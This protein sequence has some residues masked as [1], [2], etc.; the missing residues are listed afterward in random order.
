MTAR[1]V[2]ADEQVG[3]VDD[4]RAVALERGHL[5]HR[6]IGE[7]IGLPERCLR[8]QPLGVLLEAVE[9]ERLADEPLGD[10]RAHVAHRRGIPEREPELGLQPL[11][12][13]ERGRPPRVAKVVGHRF[14]AE[15]VLAGFE[16]RPG[17]LEVRVARCAD[18][19]EVDVIPLD[20]RAMVGGDG[21]NR[22]AL[23]RV[24]RQVC[25]R[26]GDGDEL[27]ARIAAKSGEMRESG[28]G[29]RAQDPHAKAR[30]RHRV[31]RSYF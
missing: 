21:G 31:A 18:V 5:Q 14:L 28:P 25:L 4:G 22:E 2:R 29:A 9:D 8:I 13:R 16:R 17:Q 30:C 11:V 3:D 19:D 1:E 27:A 7:V 12:P 15:H 6:L 26:V 24:P 23:G 20:Q 10:Q